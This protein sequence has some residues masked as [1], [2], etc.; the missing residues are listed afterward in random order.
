MLKYI[1]VAGLLAGCTTWADQRAAEYHAQ[2]LDC[3][4]GGRGSLAMVLAPDTWPRAK[5]CEYAY[6]QDIANLNSAMAAGGVTV[7]P[8]YVLGR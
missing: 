8:V 1:V 3:L 6:E 4:N 7:Q 2:Y 5:R